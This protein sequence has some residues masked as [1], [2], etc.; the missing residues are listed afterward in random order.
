M[1]LTR[2]DTPP[3]TLEFGGLQ[4]GWFTLPDQGAL[5]G[6]EDRY[7]ATYGAAPHTLASLAYDG[8]RAIAETV[9][10]TGR[11]GGADLTASPGFQGAGGVFFACCPT[12][13]T[14]GRW[15]SPK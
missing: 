11:V 1:G 4:G 13:P 9:A 8:V 5:A 10:T 6:F 14:R 7:A 12:A 2:W 3:Q 15:R